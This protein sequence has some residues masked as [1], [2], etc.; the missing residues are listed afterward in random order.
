MQRRRKLAQTA[1]AQLLTSEHDRLFWNLIVM[2]NQ[3]IARPIS[4]VVAVGLGVAALLGWDWFA[5]YRTNLV[6]EWELPIL[7]L[8]LIVAGLAPT[9]IARKPSAKPIVAF[10]LIVDVVTFI[11]WLLERGLVVGYGGYDVGGI[12]LRIIAYGLVLYLLLPMMSVR[13]EQSSKVDRT[14][15]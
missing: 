9:K 15:R 7:S 12:A 13:V 14:P 5:Q 8:L 6:D 1:H 3:S 11:W 4:R 2:S 10:L